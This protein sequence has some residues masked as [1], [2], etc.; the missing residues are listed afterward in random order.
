MCVYL[1]HINPERSLKLLSFAGA[2]VR[3]MHNKEIERDGEKAQ[4][5]KNEKQNI[6]MNKFHS[7][8]EVSFYFKRTF[9]IVI[10]ARGNL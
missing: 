4:E 5:N 8:G 3:E 7:L 1:T 2:K 6:F 9:I 10:I